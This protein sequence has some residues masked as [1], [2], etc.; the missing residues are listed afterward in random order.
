MRLNS[1][2][3]NGVAVI[4]FLVP[5]LSMGEERSDKSVRPWDY[6]VE[7]RG[8]YTLGSRSSWTEESGN[9]FRAKDEPDYSNG[10]GNSTYGVAIGIRYKNWGVSLARENENGEDVSNDR[11]S[12][13]ELVNWD[14]KVP[15]KRKN[16][17]LE[18]DHHWSITDYFDW[19]SVFGI[20]HTEYIMEENQATATA[21]G[22]QGVI[23]PGIPF[24]IGLHSSSSDI[25]YRLGGGIS[26]KIFDNLA[27]KTILQVTDYGTANLQTRD[28][29]NADGNRGISIDSQVIELSARLQYAF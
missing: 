18:I 24:R 4:I 29:F 25:A 28:P 10:M 12:V 26:Y 5:S 9:P 20:G 27:F 17:M 2:I 14:L 6:T 1:I 7:L 3:I 15:Y 16:W 8:A 11:E 19:I 22:T 21:V 13:N 23:A